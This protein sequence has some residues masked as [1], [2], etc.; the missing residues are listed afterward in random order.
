MAARPRGLPSARHP[1]PAEC[2]PAGARAP[3]SSDAAPV[4]RDPWGSRRHD[5]YL[6]LCL[7]C[8]VRL[9]HRGCRPLKASTSQLLPEP[10]PPDE[11]N[12]RLEGC[13]PAPVRWPPQP[14]PGP[15]QVLAVTGLFAAMATCTGSPEHRRG[16][17]Q[18]Q[19]QSQLSFPSRGPRGAPVR[20]VGTGTRCKPRPALCPPVAPGP[21][22]QARG[23]AQTAGLSGEASAAEGG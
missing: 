11:R 13:A 21:K 5:R 1:A 19:F 2:Q 12:P 8:W 10:A 9:G 17:G 6:L 23:A 22:G 16:A 18:P 3:R 7:P 15:P 14:Q 20:G 4:L